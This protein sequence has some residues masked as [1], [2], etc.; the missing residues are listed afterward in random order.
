MILR[1]RVLLLVLLALASVAARVAWAADEDAPVPKQSGHGRMQYVRVYVPVDRLRLEDCRDESVRYL[2]VDPDQFERLLSSVETTGRATPASSMAAVVSARYTARLEG[3]TLVDGEASLEVVHPT[4]G[5]VMLP[6]DPCSLA[7]DEASWAGEQA[8]IARVG[9]DADKRLGLLVEPPIGGASSCPTG[10]AGRLQFGWSLR[11]RRDPTGAVNFQWEVPPC[12]ATCLV[13]DLPSGVTLAT[14]HG[15]VVE[16]DSGGKGTRRWRIE[17]GRH[18]RVGIR[19]LPTG[20][21]GG[22]LPSTRVRQSTKYYFSLQGLEVRTR[23]ELDVC[24]Q[25]LRHV[26]L[27]LDPG[28]RLVDAVYTKALYGETP[29]EWTVVS[30]SPGSQD[31]RVI[32]EFPERVEGTKRI[33][34]VRALAPLQLDRRWRLPAIRPEGMFWQEGKAALSVP[35]PLELEQLAATQGRQ[36]SRIDPLAAPRL[37][38]TVEL[39]YFTPDAATEIV[40]SLPEAPLELDSGSIVELSGGEVIAR[41]GAELSVMH[42]KRY[43]LEADVARQWIIDSVEAVP[44]DILADWRIEGARAQSKLTIELAKSLPQSSSDTP[45]VR[46]LIAGRRLQSPLRR[47]LAIDDLTPLRFRGTTHGRRLMW[48]RAREPYELKLTGAETLTRV[49]PQDLDPQARALFS[50]PPRDPLFELDAGTAGSSAVKVLLE[51]RKPSYSA[52]IQVEATLS[53]HSLIESYRLDCVPQTARVDRVLVRFSRPRT[54]PV[55]WTLGAEEEGQWTAERLSPAVRQASRLASE[56]EASRLASEGQ[57]SRPASGGETW[58]IRLDRPRSVPFQIR[59]VRTTQLTERQAVSLA[60][61]PEASVQ[62]GTVVVRSTGSTSVWIQNGGLKPI[63]TATAPADRYNTA[64]A[65][66]RYDPVR[67][68]A[69]DAERALSLWRLE[70][71]HAPPSAWVWSCSLESRFESS[72]AGRHLATYRLE[73]A[74]RERLRLTLPPSSARQDV[75]GVWVD[76]KQASCLPVGNEAGRALAI[77]LP[78]GERFPVASICFATTGRPLGVVE[79][80]TPPLPEVD[81]PVLECRWTVWL[82]PGYGAHASNLHSP[83]H[84]SAAMSWTERLFGPLGQRPDHAPFDPF[85]GEDWLRMVHGEPARRSAEDKAGAMLRRLGEQQ[86]TGGLDWGTLLADV[87]V[88][89]LLSADGLS[90]QPDLDLLVDRPALARLGLAPRTP[91]H[92]PRGGAPARSGA[93]LLEAA[94]LTLLVHPRAIVVTSAESAAVYQPQLGPVAGEGRKRLETGVLRWIHPGPL[95]DRVGRAAAGEPDKSFVPAYVWQQ[96]PAAPKLPWTF[97]QPGGFQPVD[98]R[99]WTAYRLDISDRLPVRLSV[100]RRDTMR[101]FCWAVFLAVIGLAWWKA[102][103]RPATLTALLG[104][105]GVAALLLPE[106]YAQVAAGGVLGTLF[107]L[108]LR[109]TRPK[110]EPA[111][112][113][114]HSDSQSLPWPRSRATIQVSILV[115]A[116]SALALCARA[117]GAEPQSKSVPAWWPAHG[118]LVPVDNEMQPTGDKYLVPEDFYKELHRL[119]TTAAQQPQG[120]L[121]GEATYSGEL[122]WQ[123]ASER[124]VLSELEATFH[125]EVLSPSARV[126]IPFGGEG[127]GLMPDGALL[128]GRPIQPELQQSTLVFSVP[129]P[130]GYQLELLLNPAVRPTATSEGSSSGFDLA[131]PPL[132]TSR[133]ELRIPADAPAIDVRSALGYVRQDVEADP[134]RVEALLGPTDRLSVR[135]PDGVGRGAPGRA[136]EVEELLWL[137]VKPGSVQLDARF[138]LNVVEGRV[139][140]LRLAADPRLRLRPVQGVQ[141]ETTPGQLQ[142][143]RLQLAQPASDQAI[144]EATFLLPEASGIGNLRLPHLEVLDAY[145]KRRW[146]AVSVDPSLQAEEQTPD[147]LEKVG[148]PDF[149]A[150]WGEAGDH[151]SAAGPEPRSVY[152]LTSVEPPWSMSVRPRE[153]DTTVDQTLCWSFASGEAQARLT[154]R[155]K[156]TAGYV[157]QYRVSAPTKFEVDSVSVLEGGAQRADRWRRAPDG[158]ITVFLKRAVL[159]EQELSLRGRL[160]TPTRGKLPLPILEIDGAKLQSSVIQLFR[161]PEV[162]V[163]VSKSVGLV[164]VEG[165]TVD[166]SRATFGRLVKWFEREPAPASAGHENAP[167]NGQPRATLTLSP[168]RPQ[169]RLK[170]ITSL[171]FDGEAWEAEAAFRINVDHG[172]LDELRLSIPP[173]CTGPYQ[174]EPPAVCEEEE[175]PQEGHRRL[176]IRPAHSVGHVPCPTDGRAITGEHRLVVSCSLQPAPGDRLSVPEMVLEQSKLEEHVLVLPTRLGL[177]PIAWETDGLVKTRLPDD[178]P[179]WPVA[180]ESFV[181]YRVEESPFQAVLRASVEAPEVRLLDV[182]L[183][184]Q[185]DQTCRGVATFDLGSAGMPACSLRLPEGCELVQAFVAGLPA[186][187]VPAGPNRWQVPLGAKEFP[188]DVQIMFTGTVSVPDAAGRMRFDAPSLEGLPVRQTLWTIYG[189]GPCRA[190]TLEGTEGVRASSLLELEL[191]RLQT[192]KELINQ[193]ARA[194]AT[195]PEDVNS[196]FQ[197]W[198][199]RYVAS[200]NEVRLQSALAGPTEPAASVE[201]ELQAIAEEASQAADRLGTGDLLAHAAAQMPAATLPGQLWLRTLDRPQGSTCCVAGGESATITLEY[202][203]VEADGLPE[204]LVG[205][206]G[207]AVVIL[208]TVVAVRWGAFSMLLCRWP[209]LLGVLAGLAWWLWLWPSVLGWGIVL[210]SLLASLRWGWKRP[211]RSG[212]AIVPL[213]LSQ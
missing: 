119:T 168:N 136:V 140:E 147:R 81:V 122:T 22:Q 27:V 150:A 74:G 171:Y 59:A 76:E 92:L 162:Q 107:V 16:E 182:R 54:A 38:E 15:V 56:D 198:V 99:G 202:R 163:E 156:S 102:A 77:D 23:L 10:W 8:E 116:V 120:F 151:G 130:G 161:K 69:P 125:V 186:A 53:D 188:Q 113:A 35:V 43:K 175:L 91:V 29:L 84:R 19:L 34:E 11:G 166:E 41:I 139:R 21:V 206:A 132:A 49:S 1:L 4:E 44:D 104:V 93:A 25:P 165:G 169:V 172:V 55:R 185:T 207:M 191:V 66:F 60:S 209:Y 158:T 94:N 195:E 210:V 86:G 111:G 126:R 9:L 82:P 79:S 17:L 75:Q 47:S 142:T 106:T 52:T 201:T 176:I 133:L 153:S 174:I 200:R 143:I 96:Q 129:E 149:Q 178:F 42:G 98:T 118:I 28:L 134:P 67:D 87:S 50:E 164:E 124:L 121:L 101:A 57:A 7:L 194:T 192:L 146:M 184:W 180:P 83:Q 88:E 155:L 13:L 12:P 51:T 211:R 48:L 64:R 127:P 18:H 144:V 145:R 199:R 30:P 138:L 212:S 85:S 193:A 173:Q 97:S 63:P 187:P 183:A 170:Q 208:L 103:H 157:F 190:G 5:R 40:L 197:A 78:P 189:P 26:A 135:W 61:L 62:R 45:P 167:P 109:L 89:T 108:G 3:E 128:D 90:G 31:T 110:R 115:L 205:A 71:E 65:T 2:P 204:R 179:A 196:W 112:S 80:L 159:G 181:A 68:A 14:D 213:G 141:V 39:Q 58:E 123:P 70:S 148:V 131:I 114:A 152:S 24:G 33:V 117:R 154:A 203:R 37:G 137:K 95:F 105:F 160:P 177:Q 36:S 20:A 100:V 46:L 32:L 72:G 6:L 73:N